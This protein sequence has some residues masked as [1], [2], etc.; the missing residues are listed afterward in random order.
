MIAGVVALVAA[1][2]VVIQVVMVVVIVHVMAPPCAKHECNKFKKGEKHMEF[3]K[4]I[5]Q[6]NGITPRV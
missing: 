2:A 5:Q 4:K 1:M 6:T 3:Q